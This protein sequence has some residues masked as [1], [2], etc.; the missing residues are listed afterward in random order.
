MKKLDKF[1][2]RSLLAMIG[3][4]FMLQAAFA[5]DIEVFFA[6]ESSSKRAKSNIMFIIDTSGSMQWAVDGTQT[7]IALEDRRINIVKS[8][9]DD[10]LTDM[11]GVNAGLMRF[12]RYR[13]GPV[14]FPALDID[15]PAVPVVEKEVL[16]GKN[17]GSEDRYGNVSLDDS[18]L[19]LGSYNSKFWALRFE[20]LNIPQ[21]A[22]I[23]R[24][25]ITFTSDR[26]SSY[27]VSSFRI[28][29]QK[30]PT[31][32]A[33]AEL[34]HNISARKTIATSNTVNWS[35]SRWLQRESHYTP[36]ISP[37][38][39]EV[40][41]QDAWCGGNDMVLLIEKLSGTERVAY[42]SEGRAL[43]GSGDVTVSSPRLN[44]EFDPVL[45]T[46][47]N[48]CV[49]PEQK[50]FKVDR[51]NHDVED[52]SSP[53]TPTML[54]FHKD[55]D[56]GIAFSNVSIDKGA[57]ITDAYIEFTSSNNR[58]YS[59][60]GMIYAVNSSSPPLSSAMLTAPRLSNK[61]EWQNIDP[62][63]TDKVYRSP[64]VKDLVKGIISRA[65][66]NSGDD[67]AFVVDFDSNSSSRSARARDY[68]SSKAPKL[69]VSLGAKKYEPG[70]ITLKQ[71]LKHAV[72]NLPGSGNTPISD[73][74][75]EAGVYF[76]GGKVT[77]GKTRSNR[78]ENRVSHSSSYKDGTLNTPSGCDMEQSPGAKSCKGEYISGAPRYI[79]PIEESCQSNHIVYLTDGAPNEHHS[80][81]DDI[82]KAW[83]GGSCSNGNAKADCAV[84]IARY[85]HENDVAPGIVGKQ[86]VTTHMIG[87]GRQADVQLMK[88]MAEAGG[89][90]YYTAQSK[91]QLVEAFSSIVGSIDAISSTFV[92]TGVSVNQYNRLTHSDQL[93]Y[94]LF[95]P[96]NE[97]VWPG[98]IKRYRLSNGTIVD[99]NGQE[100]I[101]N[102]E[103]SEDAKSFWSNIKDG[104]DVEKG[105][106]SEKLTKNRTI[107]SNIATTDITSAA[108]RFNLTNVTTELLGVENEADRR[109]TI[110]WAQGYDV[111]DDN[112][113]VNAP[114]AAP[115]SQSM[116]EPLHSPP[117]V[118]SYKDGSLEGNAVYVGTN[119]GFFRAI[120]TKTGKEV[121]SFIPRELLSNLQVLQSGASET[122]NYGM[123]GDISV[124]I[125]DNNKN[126]FVD[127]GTDKAYLY[128]GMRRGG[129]SYYMLDVSDPYKPKMGFAISSNS[130]A[131]P[132][133]VTNGY[134]RLGQTWSKPAIGKMNIPGVNSDKLVMIFGGGYDL[135]QDTAGVSLE[136]T[137]GNI[138]YIA[139][140]YTGK[141]LWSSD[142]TIDPNENEGP[143]KLN[144]VPADLTAFDLDG[145]EL[146]DSFYAS[147]TKA[148]IF[149]FDVDNETGKIKGGR[150]ASLQSAADE[151]NNRRFYYPVDAAL[152]RLV[153]ES[154]VSL[155]IGSGF[156][157]HPLNTKINDHFYMIKDKGVLNRK[158]DM[159][160]KL[161]NL[162]NVTNLVGDTDNDGKSDASTQMEND[163]NYGWY[164]DFTTEGEK[165]IEKSF[166]FNNIVFFTTYIPKSEN[167]ICKAAAGGGRLYGVKVTDGN[168]YI[169]KEGEDLKEDDRYQELATPGIAPAG[170]II[171]TPESTVIAIGTEIIEPAG[172]NP[173]R[174]VYPTRWLNKKAD[175]N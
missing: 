137:V 144:S 86:T 20:D 27:D 6:P 126:G 163:G 129:N 5:E 166:T 105:G 78:N 75:A 2:S 57:D 133:V 140:A 125:E 90:G 175:I 113:D 159:D 96:K 8:V 170:T 41:G 110:H 106:L 72:Q 35:V 127:V 160:I 142:S 30:I 139:D 91:D 116:A 55:R 169:Q 119:D 54:D 65:D 150:I 123:D 76:T 141:L 145:D 100:A 60:G 153:G 53:Q 83:T 84:E 131:G 9:M 154:F 68:S 109:K 67:I 117:T 50:V 18:R 23:K 73:T 12:N 43:A 39:Q 157:A 120:D 89:G 40:I 47:A 3:S 108:N 26:D 165:V 59:A 80:E 107:F 34:H 24:A 168:P 69:V 52:I 132:G 77:Y 1:L 124:Y 21:G 4:F 32:P 128:V 103:F 130:N 74:M 112:Y 13:G 118:V 66:W 93:Y 22:K 36:D 49:L 63:E 25:S 79:S 99:V 71:N 138:V 152:I 42:S 70:D 173:K 14:L 98:N 37:V 164:I 161:D 61:V 38:I 134:S 167:D 64:S 58:S 56:V 31:A 11:T 143:L 33:F 16:Y 101:V 149:R 156:R 95:T 85:L 82:Y 158:F 104:N 48:G 7:G 162:T 122:H 87:F 102:A 171:S 121:W 147:D 115:A 10:L 135:K 172:L 62:W 94:A 46:G 45:P 136:D 29:A 111:E 114:D 15:S 151:V 97:A 88:N 17:D 44:I 146:V 155:S 148:Q 51:A 28:S 81:T 174:N 19:K 92:T